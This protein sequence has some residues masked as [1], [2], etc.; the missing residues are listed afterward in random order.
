MKIVLVAG[1]VLAVLGAGGLTGSALTAVSER[2]PVADDASQEPTDEPTDDTEDTDDSDEGSGK[3]DDEAK[4]A[5][6][7]AQHAFVSAKQEWTSCVGEAAPAHEPGSGPFDPED[8]CGTKPHPHDGDDE[9]PGASGEE[10]DP[11]LGKPA[12]AG[13]PDR[14]TAEPPGHAARDQAS[15]GR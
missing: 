2:P 3:P 6:H 1:A 13:G 15:A 4:D 11:G 10:R 7:A 14:R 8:A 5:Q 9:A 12:W